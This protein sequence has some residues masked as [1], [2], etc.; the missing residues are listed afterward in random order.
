MS[1]LRSINVLSCTFTYDI[2]LQAKALFVYLFA[3]NCR[4]GPAKARRLV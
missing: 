3:F 2:V 1:T 4:S